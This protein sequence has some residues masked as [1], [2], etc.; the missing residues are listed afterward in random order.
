MFDVEHVVMLRLASEDDWLN[1][2]DFMFVI[3]LLF[4]IS[5]GLGS[6]TVFRD[7]LG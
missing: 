4:L 3:S 6:M 5:D 2:A 1:N 7:R